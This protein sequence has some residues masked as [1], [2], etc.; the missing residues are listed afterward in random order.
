M[1]A[2]K[3]MVELAEDVLFGPASRAERYTARRYEAFH[4]AGGLGDYSETPKGWRT[5]SLGTID[6]GTLDDA[7]AAVLSKQSLNAKDRLIIR[8]RGHHTARMYEGQPLDWLHIYA[9][10][11]RSAPRYEYRDHQRH[12]SHDRYAE[13]LC[14][15]DGNTL[16]GAGVL[17]HG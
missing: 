5:K 7:L 8:E 12:R 4:L 9:I 3:F 15:I 11:Q 6:A 17:T 1:N 16:L 10:R 14:T 13:H 2:S